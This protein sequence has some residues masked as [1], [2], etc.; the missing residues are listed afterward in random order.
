MNNE[1]LKKIFVDNWT[2]IYNTILGRDVT[3]TI[4]SVQVKS[5][6]EV[7]Q[8]IRGLQSFIRISYG[9]LPG[10]VMVLGLRNKLISI[11]ANLMIGL[12]SFRDDITASDKE[13]FVEAV[14]QMFTACRAP[15]KET[16]DMDLHFRD[17]AFIEP[18]DPLQPIGGNNVQLWII[19]MTL[20]GIAVEKFVLMAPGNF[21]ASIQ[22]EEDRIGKIMMDPVDPVDPVGRFDRVASPLNTSAAKVASPAPPN[23]PRTGVSHS[24]IDI[25]MDVEIPIT[26]RIGST[27]M[28]LIDIMHLG[29][30]SIIELEK[31]VDDPV[32]IL[33]NGKLVAKGEIVVC[34]GNYA[35]KITEVQSKEE[36]IRSLA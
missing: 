5:K 25:L 20:P 16:L 36:R 31:M 2:S 23:R 33:A 18:G 35:V 22:E 21:A 7:A 26:V 17:T 13:T 4:N 1:Q 6:K 24:N 30:G 27:E 11:V 29:L 14:T 15:L 28:R 12:D 8:L 32:E 34:D 19:T 10:E 3:L 9:E